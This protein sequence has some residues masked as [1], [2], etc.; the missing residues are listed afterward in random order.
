MLQLS[1]ATLA[2][3]SKVLLSSARG[4]EILMEKLS[5]Q[6]PPQVIH[7]CSV[8]EDHGVDPYASYIITEQSSRQGSAADE[9]STGQVSILRFTCRVY[10]QD[11][12]VIYSRERSHCT[13]MSVRSQAAQPSMLAN[14]RHQ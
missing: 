13:F 1:D 14:A 2:A 5:K 6:I 4:R 9:C 11:T 12:N 3:S 8:S 10:C 7:L